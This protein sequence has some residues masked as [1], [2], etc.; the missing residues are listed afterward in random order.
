MEILIGPEAIYYDVPGNK[1]IT[2]FAIITTS[3]IVLHTFDDI[4]PANF[5]LDI[6][7]CK[8]FNI[9]SVF[10]HIEQFKPESIKF[11]FLDRENNFKVI[12]SS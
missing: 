3:H 5:E 11:K 12:S 7:S 10:Q 6:Y 8:D 4:I 2:A 1:G 9:D